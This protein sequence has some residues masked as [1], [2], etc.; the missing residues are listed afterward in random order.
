MESRG[1]KEE[2]S[3]ICFFVPFFSIGYIGKLL[4]IESRIPS[5]IE[6]YGVFG[7]K[8]SRFPYSG[9]VRKRKITK[10]LLV[11][12]D[13]AVIHDTF[14]AIY[15]FDSTVVYYSFI[16]AFIRIPISMDYCQLLDC[17]HYLSV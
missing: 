8:I 17:L 13:H 11:L 15:N 2:V 12:L 5:R 9:F 3:Q 6:L 7:F 10:R 14:V 16:V 1:S 4:K